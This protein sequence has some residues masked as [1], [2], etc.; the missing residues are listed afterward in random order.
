MKHLNA[1]LKLVSPLVHGA[2]HSSIR[3]ANLP[4]GAGDNYLPFRR[5]P[6]AATV[7]GQP[8]IIEL[9]VVSGNSIRGVL[10]RM[11]ANLT[12]KALGVDETEIPDTIYY[13]LF[14]G[15]GLSAK[16]A[17]G[18]TEAEEKGQ[19]PL[20]VR[21]RKTL[22]AVFPLM[23]LFGSSYGNKMLEGLINVGVCL[24]IVSETRLITGKDSERSWS[25]DL[26][27]YQLATRRDD[28]PKDGQELTMAKAVKA[29]ELDI[30]KDDLKKLKDKE[31]SKQMI[32]YQEVLAPG[33]DMDHWI[34]FKDEITLMEESLM[35]LILE[36]FKNHP[37]LGGKSA[38]GFGRFEFTKFYNDGQ[39]L[40]PGSTYLKWLEVHKQTI[41]E[42]MG[43]W[44]NPKK[45]LALKDPGQPFDLKKNPVKVVWPAELAVKLDEL[46]TEREALSRHN[47]SETEIRAKYRA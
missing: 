3:P 10:R 35:S 9:P 43:C 39:A 45:V 24:P 42:Y 19:F 18:N 40:E 37:Y 36:E 15:G 28:L 17:E 23:S 6:I 13:F 12:M 5:M 33:V 1:T 26:L 14:S 2:E 31:S 29:L 38:S 22:R 46:V 27:S 16:I 32:Y 47:D 4:E 8:E 21:N 34:D 7:N 11:G 25:N 20:L 41:L 44:E 30:S